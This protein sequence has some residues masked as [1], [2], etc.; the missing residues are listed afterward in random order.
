[1]I[2]SSNERPLA[3]HRDRLPISGTARHATRFKPHRPGAIPN[4]SSNP[5]A[6]SL[7]HR[8]GCGVSGPIHDRGPGLR[9]AS[10]TGSL[11]PLEGGDAENTNGGGRSASTQVVFRHGSMLGLQQQD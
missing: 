1:M 10:S 6:M 9:T 4:G 3:F 11:Y 8:K 5:A 7:N 2:R